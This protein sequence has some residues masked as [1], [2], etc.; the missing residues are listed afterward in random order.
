M[1]RSDS[2]ALLF[3]EALIVVARIRAGRQ[4]LGNPRLF[5]TQM[6]NSLGAAEKAA[7]RYGYPASD[8]ETVLKAMAAFL[9]ESLLNAHSPQYAGLYQELF[10][11]TSA[12]E[13]FVRNLASLFER[14]D[15]LTVA[16][17]LE[18]HQL[19]LLLGFQTHLSGLEIRY[20]LREI[21]ER[22]HRIRNARPTPQ[23]LL[24]NERPGQSESQTVTFLVGGT[25]AG[26][27]SLIAESG[28]ELEQA[29]ENA[30]RMG[31][32]L[33]V[34]GSPI[35]NRRLFRRGDACSAVLVLDCDAFLAHERV[36]T[37]AQTARDSRAQLAEIA[38][39][40]RATLPVHVVF[41]KMDKLN[42]FGAFARN[43]TALEG[44]EAMGASVCTGANAAFDTVYRWL[45]DKRPKLL[46]REC[47]P[48]E[49]PNIF[50]FPREFAKL[51]PL[52][53]QFLTELSGPTSILRGFYFTGV[54]TFGG[55]AMPRRLWL[56]G[57]F[58]E[59]VLSNTPARK[60]P[61]SIRRR[62]SISRLTGMR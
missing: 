5:R 15:S 41:T 38:R 32:A 58:P 9:D 12:G 17:V 45:A 62:I 11:A 61:G 53:V 19:C 54:A 56:Q 60:P 33:L 27:T 37:I 8:L 55:E 25:G 49:L 2:L 42:H 21:G 46:E 29:A 47:N 28:I 20:L 57:L 30:W 40:T 22:I 6:R 14:P 13:S 1:S 23:P 18:V 34:D 59:I 44:R 51:R 50:E 16:D 39:A 7:S 52:I 35:A 48:R 3:Q 10:G 43:F 31:E 4:R 26:K 24:M 36:E